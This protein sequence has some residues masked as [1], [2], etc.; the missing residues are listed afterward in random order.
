M[1]EFI[2]FHI[3]TVASAAIILSL[4]RWIRDLL[5]IFEVHFPKNK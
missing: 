5:M 1:V 2:K 4:F 3:G